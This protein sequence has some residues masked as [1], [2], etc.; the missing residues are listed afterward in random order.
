[1]HIIH[2]WKKTYIKGQ[3]TFL[4][5]KYQFDKKTGLIYCPTCGKVKKKSWGIWRDLKGREKEIFDRKFKESSV[6][7]KEKKKTFK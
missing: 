4:E 2:K 1:M 7:V 3:R 5:V 6:F